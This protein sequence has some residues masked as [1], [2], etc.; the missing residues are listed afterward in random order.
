MKL[1]PINEKLLVKII[2]FSEE[3]KAGSLILPAAMSKDFVLA[4]IVDMGEGQI[5]QEGVRLPFV[6]KVGDR[7][8]LSARSGTE[9]RVGADLNKLITER[10]V[11]AIVK[12]L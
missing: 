7:V 2:D 9:I 5:T 12:E 8:M 11:M 4:E 1:K 6:V 3:M 10:D